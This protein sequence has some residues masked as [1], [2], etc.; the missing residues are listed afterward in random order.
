MTSITPHYLLLGTDVAFKDSQLAKIQ[1]ETFKDSD[2][3]RLDS[4]TLDGHKL[5]AERLKVALLSLPALGRQRLIHIR[6]AERLTKQNIALLAEFFKAGHAHA[7]VVLDALAWDGTG[8]EHRSVRDAVKILGRPA[9]KGSTVFQMMDHVIAGEMAVALKLLK[10]LF[11][12]D[13]QPERLLGGMVW[14]WSN[15]AKPRLRPDAYKKGLLVL[16]EA[17]NHIK[18]SRFPEREYALEVATVKLSLL[19][20]A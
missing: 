15:N 7:V 16:Q 5:S 9:E 18:R 19:T 20:K 3:L 11:E 14:A 2:A 8:E 17:D 13:E 6:Q 12:R 1:K 10:T 4:E